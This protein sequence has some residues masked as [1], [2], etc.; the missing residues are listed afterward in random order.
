MFENSRPVYF[1]LKYVLQVLCERKY[2]IIQVIWN[3]VYIIKSVICDQLVDC[4]SY[5]WRT[6][7]FPEYYRACIYIKRLCGQN[8]PT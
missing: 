6:P 1:S 8:S 5:K 2:P 4:G 7:G 3:F